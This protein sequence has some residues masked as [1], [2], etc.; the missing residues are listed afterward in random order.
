MRDRNG[1]AKMEGWKHGIMEDAVPV[2]HP[3]TLPFFNPSNL[4][5][6]KYLL[7]STCF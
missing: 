3:S 4:P 5:G 2:I 1:K 6:F 7:D